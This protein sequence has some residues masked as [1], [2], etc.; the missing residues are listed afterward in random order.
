MD[1]SSNIPPRWR[2]HHPVFISLQEQYIFG[3]WDKSHFFL[4]GPVPKL[5]TSPQA[6]IDVDVI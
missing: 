1:S 3:I 4:L 6:F 2:V 5:P